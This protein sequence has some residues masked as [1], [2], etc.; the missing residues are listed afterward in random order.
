M[1]SKAKSREKSAIAIVLSATAL[2]CWASK[3]IADPILATG[4]TGAHDPSAVTMFGS[5]NFIYFATGQGIVSRRSNDM[6]NWVDAPPVFATPPAWTETAVPGFTGFFWAPDVSYF[7]GL[8]H[9]YYA[10]STFG[11]QVSAIG[12]ATNV[13]MNPSSFQYDWVDQGPVIQSTTGNDYNA[14]D[15]SVLA[16][17]NGSV[18]MSLGSYNDGIYVAQINP[19]TGMR[20]NSTLTRI[21]DNSSIEASY[22]YQH[23]GY[24]YLFVNFGS[25]CMGVDSTYNIRVGRSTSIT[26]PYFDENGVPMVSGGGTLLL[27][28]EGRYIGPGQVGIMDDNN[29]YWMSYHY[30]DG[31]NDG[32]PT[33]ALEQMY[34]SADNWPTLT[35]SPEPALL[36]LLIAMPLTLRRRR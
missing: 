19:T 27:G 13:T 29:Q 2:T 28:S 1:H 7:D 20:E 11:S 33:F 18:W 12:M 6:I 22:L 34:W 21:A 32:T 23:N 15:P 24:Y 25:C 17:T 16:D 36:A 5:S 26:G 9:M 4:D 10:V 3:L 30:Y 31:D 14:I 8:Y 35:V